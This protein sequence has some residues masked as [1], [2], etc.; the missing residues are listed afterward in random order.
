[1]N[2]KSLSYYSKTTNCSRH[3][4][5]ARVGHSRAW[6]SAILESIADLLADSLVAFFGH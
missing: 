2:L 4:S 3:N 6:P 1:M 5:N